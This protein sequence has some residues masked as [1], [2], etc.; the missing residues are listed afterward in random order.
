MWSRVKW[1]VVALVVIRLSLC[2][3]AQ[4]NLSAKRVIDADQ[5]FVSLLGFDYTPK[6]HSSFTAAFKC[7]QNAEIEVPSET[8]RILERNRNMIHDVPLEK[9]MFSNDEGDCEATITTENSQRSSNDSFCK[10]QQ[11]CSEIVNDTEC[12]N[13]NTS[14]LGALTYLGGTLHYRTAGWHTVDILADEGDMLN[15]TCSTY[16]NASFINDT[17]KWE[18]YPPFVVSKV[19]DESH[20]F[21]ATHILG[22][23]CVLTIPAVS[24]K[25]VGTWTCVTNG[26]H[27]TTQKGSITLDVTCTFPIILSRRSRIDI[28]VREDA[29]RDFKAC[30]QEIREGTGSIEYQCYDDAITEAVNVSWVFSRLNA[31]CNVL[32]R[33]SAKCNAFNEG[34]DASFGSQ[35]SLRQFQQLVQLLH[36]NDPRTQISPALIASTDGRVSSEAPRTVGITHAQPRSSSLSGAHRAPR[37]SLSTVA[38]ADKETDTEAD[39]RDPK[40]Q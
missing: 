33:G 5:K 29:F 10:F 17:C 25:Y 11:K 14:S 26:S 1:R 16:A 12:H 37:R 19:K 8:C 2:R 7:E 3:A 31:L 15:L 32:N 40:E 27:G 28:C 13:W 34:D 36:E 30:L 24:R 23:Q 35:D 4:V 39:E 18:Q 21:S 20:N 6:T 22:K 38:E 9:N